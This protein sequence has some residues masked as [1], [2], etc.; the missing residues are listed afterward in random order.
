MRLTLKV[1]ERLAEV[2][3]TGNASNNCFGVKDT[4]KSS[5]VGNEGVIENREDDG[6]GVKERSNSSTV[7]RLATLAC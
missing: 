6:G 3:G 4:F 1:R 7:E 5:T 2:C